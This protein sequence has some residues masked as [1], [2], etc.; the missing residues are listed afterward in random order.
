MREYNRQSGSRKAGADL[1]LSR[2]D[3]ASG[4][5]DDERY[6]DARGSLYG[7]RWT[8]DLDVS[9][10]PPHLLD[11]AQQFVDAA[12]DELTGHDVNPQVARNY[13]LQARRALTG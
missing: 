4:L 9:T 7:R 10:V 3:A 12:C 13:L 8:E 5:V 11:K 1:L 6:W 2:L